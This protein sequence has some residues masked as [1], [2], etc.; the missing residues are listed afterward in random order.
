MH[1]HER[2]IDDYLDDELAP[3]RRA[4]LEAHVAACSDCRI[5]LED[6]RRLKRRLQALSAAPC[7]AL[8]DAEL[9]GRLRHYPQAVG[10]PPD[11]P[12]NRV[13]DLGQGSRLR[14]MAPALASLAV[15]AMVASVLLAAWTLGGP[16]SSATGD[17]AAAAWNETGTDLSRT[18]LRR[19]R[20]QGWNAPVLRTSGLELV[21]ALGSAGNGNRTLTME[22]AGPR[23]NVVL[24]ERRSDPVSLFATSVS[25]PPAGPVATGGQLAGMLTVQTRRIDGEPVAI[26]NMVDGATRLDVGSASYELRS[27]LNHDGTEQV[28]HRIVAT[29][30]ARLAPGLDGGDGTW[31][32]IGRG[33]TRLLVLD[34]DH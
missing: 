21:R 27:S 8:P 7:H 5:V 34:T 19:L 23:G 4:A 20:D 1:R 24:T 30:H 25:Q 6:R 14:T 11:R 9:L 22:Y 26:Q 28:V 10:L 18:V 32:R 33:M 13:D 31:E 2:W 17:G 15:L 16:D 3:Q 12:G 29:E